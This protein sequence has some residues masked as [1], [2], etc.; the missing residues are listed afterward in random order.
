MQFPEIDPVILAIGPF[1]IRWYALAYIV[2]IL[3]GCYL[4]NILNKKPPKLEGL[5]PFDDLLV[6]GICG[7]ILGGRLGYVLFYNFSYYLQNPLDIIKIWHGGMSFHG[8]LIGVI[9]AVYIFSRRKNYPFFQLI[10]LCAVVAPIGLFFGRI[11][12]FINAELYGRATD[13]PWGIIF[14]NGGDLPRHPSQIYE[15]LLEGVVLFFVMFFMANYTKAREKTGTLSGV[16]LIGYSLSRMF[17]ELFR[18]PDAQIGFFFANITMGQILSLP[19]LLL[20]IYL[21][22]AGSAIK[23]T[24]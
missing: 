5:K 10:D 18:E 22:K 9:L 8:G 4:I 6:Y 2:G 3:L 12:N 19:M 7:I 23:S 24:K 15:A 13:V 1:A 16:F 17:V 11:A 21:I 14:P 20:G